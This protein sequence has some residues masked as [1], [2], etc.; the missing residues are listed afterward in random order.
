VKGLGHAFR[1]LGL[2]KDGKRLSTFTAGASSGMTITAG[3]PSSFAASATPW[4][5]LPEE[6]ATTPRVRWSASSW[7]R[8]L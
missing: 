6:K 8:R 3:R 4:A 5:W 2:G 7:T 1:P